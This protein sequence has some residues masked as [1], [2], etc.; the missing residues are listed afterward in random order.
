MA[1]KFFDI[2]PPQLAS[3]I[4]EKLKGFT[5]GKKTRKKAGKDKKRGTHF[6]LRGIL[7]SA[8]IFSVLI[9]VYLYFNLAS[10]TVEIWPK[11]EAVI[12]EQEITAEESL[13]E[14]ELPTVHTQQDKKIPAQLIEEEKEL[15]QEFPATGS[16]SKEGL[17]QG[18]IR[19]YNK[20]NPPTSISLKA[21]TRFL[22]D[23]GKYFRSVD[24]INLP[25]AQL[26]SG[27]ITPSWVDVKVIAIESGEAYNIDPA[28]FSVPGLV[29]TAF[30]YSIYGKS[31]EKMTGG[32]ET[33]QKLVTAEDIDNAKNS[34]TQKL[35]TDTEQSLKDKI[36]SLNLILFNNAITKDIIESSSSVKAGAEVNSFN[37]KVKV[38]VSALVFKQSDL[39]EVAR[40]YIASQIEESKTLPGSLIGE[41][42]ALLEKSLVLEY[43]PETIDLKLGKINLNLKMS[44]EIYQTINIQ[45]MSSSFRGKSSSQISDI[46]YNKL[47]QEL[48]HL[49]INFWPFWVKKAPKNQNRIKIE[50]NFE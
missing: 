4:E 32:Y 39:E 5:S 1:K 20:Y 25:P 9:I 15:W 11:T 2:I 42:K 16:S 7:I 40:R 14:I 23:S 36:L 33:N 46:V 8:G 49:K 48:S 3:N 27:K 6:R 37:Y 45:E 38:K 22:S 43:T 47:G 19:V 18:T 17:A 26:K 30:Y 12:F 28:E 29:G 24:K 50:L 44:A 13:N 41:S 31:S 10:A 34:L 35:L 21:K